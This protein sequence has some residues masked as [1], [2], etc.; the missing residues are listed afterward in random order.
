L[1]WVYDIRRETMT[2]VTPE[3]RNS[4]A[5]WVPD[6]RRVTYAS[7]TAGEEVV[8]SKA[9]DGSGAA[10]PLPVRGQPSSWSP[11]AQAL[12]F[13]WSREAGRSNSAVWILRSG[14][15]EPRSF[16]SSRFTEAYPEFSPDGR[17][18]AYTSDETGRQEVYAQQYPGPGERRQLSN[19]GGTQPAWAHNGRELFYT[20]IDG[21]TQR[22]RMM[23]VPLSEGSPLR[24]G[25]PR[26]LFEG[27]FRDQANTRGYDVTPDGQRFLMVKPVQRPPSPVRQMVMVQNWFE[28]LKAEVPAGGAK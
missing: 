7:A 22:M 6:G 4:R 1:V 27:L 13:V 17:W 23:S 25:V 12:A 28:E 14:D 16:I 21:R 15:Q 20:E 5:I 10:V 19:N 9:A 24:A 18:V 11:D 26:V 3:G 8:V 2:L